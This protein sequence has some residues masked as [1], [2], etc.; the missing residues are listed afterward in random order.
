MEINATKVRGQ[1]VAIGEKQSKEM[2]PVESATAMQLI[3]RKTI[4]TG[5]RVNAVDTYSSLLQPRVTL[6]VWTRSQK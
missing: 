1:C 5:I 4:L 3:H 6:E 2:G